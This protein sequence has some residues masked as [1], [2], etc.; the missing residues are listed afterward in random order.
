MQ[1]FCCCGAQ[2][3]YPHAPDCP[4]PYFGRDPKREDEWIVARERL[5]EVLS[6]RDDPRPALDALLED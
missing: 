6:D 2:P 4:F 3:G 1:Q 5:Q